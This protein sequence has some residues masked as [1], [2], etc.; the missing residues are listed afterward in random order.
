MAY[1]ADV[2]EHR[3]ARMPIDADTRRVVARAIRWAWRDEQ[4]HA[5]WIRGALARRADPASW[6]AQA[7][8]QVG[9]WV[10][11]REAHFTWRESPARRLVAGAVALAGTLTGH[12]PPA[13][14]DELRWHPFRE[15][16]AFNVEAE[17]TAGLAWRR[18]AEVAVS[19]QVHPDDTVV[20]AHIAD[21]EDRHAALW[22]VLAEAFDDD[23]RLRPGWD[24][25]RLEATLGR[26][27]QRFVAVPPSGGTAWQNPLGKGAPVAV[28]E[29]DRLDGVLADVLAAVGAEGLVGPGVRVAIKT[30]FM[31]V[32]DARDPSP[33]VSPALLRRLAG[34][35]VER[36]AV[37]DV[38]EARN[39]YDV[40][41]EHRRV[42]DVAAYLDLEG[43]WRIV[44]AQQE[45]TPHG[46]LRGLGHDTIA[47]SWRDADVR[48]VL[49]KLRSHPTSV[50]TLSL[51]AAEGLCARHDE[52]VWFDRHV[53]REAAVCMALDAFPPHL[54]LLDAW[55]HVPDGLLGM[56]GTDT[57]LTPRR[58]YASRDAVSL[59]V[60][61]ARH[62]GASG[63]DGLLL[64][65]AADWFGAPTPVVDGPDTPIAGFRLPD[66]D[67]RTAALARLAMPVYTHLSGHGALFLP[68]FDT[69]AFPPRS[70]PAGRVV[71][72][73]RALVRRLTTD[74]RDDDAL[75]TSAVRVAGGRLRVARL[76]AGEPIVLLHGYPDTLQ[77]FARLAPRLAAR[78]DVVA[79]DWPGLGG[80]TAWPG[81]VDPAAL[82]ERLR[83]A[84]DALGIARAAVFGH[85]MGAQPALALAA[86]HPDRVSRVIVSNALLFGDAPTSLAIA[87]MRRAGLAQ[88]ALRAAPG[89]VFDRCL[90]TFLDGERLPEAVEA[91]LRAA[92]AQPRVR[93][94]V[95]A[96]CAAYEAALPHL[97]E[98]YWTV[99]APVHAIWGAKDA[100]FPPEHAERL[101]A[102]LPATRVDVLPAGHWMA[103]THADDV[104][105]AV[106]A[107]WTS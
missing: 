69:E 30:T 57:P 3:L 16:A 78:H 6:F 67:L 89:T 99:R 40:Y 103:F 34:W 33:T 80:S 32:A 52:G 68:D 5:L 11:S 70:A 48:I 29:G 49:G 83:A 107:A 106:E 43:D 63:H 61:A 100:H 94:T 91:D 71:R 86:H 72:A 35:C 101:R 81:P 17:R 88:V 77:I 27:G 12:V 87:W 10:S 105:A 44:D 104:A 64:D 65:W 21:D 97:P 36:G 14:R 98:L 50:V 85:D 56:L 41:H 96:M 58:L 19:A 28:R 54:A 53:D 92:W 26:I 93:D 84:L 46:Y 45:Q 75:P 66:H 31:M 47:R 20:F 38:I 90:A 39:L 4:A 25:A 82:A 73:A 7:E 15:V 1:K 22:G 60:V 24:A 102:I 2:I 37:V 9:G 13:V 51:D 18:M 42:A 95:A 59:D 74:R 62:T 76:G 79:L 23:D 55:D 8:G